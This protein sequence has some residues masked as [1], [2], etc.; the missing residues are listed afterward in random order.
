MLT[1]L[2]LVLQ[3]WWRHISDTLSHLMVDYYKIYYT[4]QYG[5]WPEVLVG[6][7]T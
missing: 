6:M 5:D 1:N 7:T 2:Q 4:V 3:Q